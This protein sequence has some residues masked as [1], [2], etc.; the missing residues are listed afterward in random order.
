MAECGLCTVD[1]LDPEDPRCSRVVFSG[2]FIEVTDSTEL[3]QATLFLFDRHPAM[4]TWP[5]DHN[6]KIHKIIFNEIWLINIYGGG[7][8]ITSI[9]LNSMKNMLYYML[10]ITYI[11]CYI[12]NISFSLMFYL[13]Y[14]FNCFNQ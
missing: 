10:F 11:I 5:T 12:H 2:N 8:S 13:Y 7:K 9:L 1:R 14:S 4:T 3:T 6:W